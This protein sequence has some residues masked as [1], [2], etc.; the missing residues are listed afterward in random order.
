MALSQSTL[1]RSQLGRLLVARK[2]L[3]E[4]Q[5]ESV[6]LIQ[7]SSGKR[8]GEVIVDQ[9]WVT[10]RQIDRALQQQSVIRWVA[11]L[12]ATILIPYQ[13][14]RAGDLAPA[15][16]DFYNPTQK[17]LINTFENQALLHG[18]ADNSELGNIA[19]IT[20]HDGEANL[21]IILQSGSDNLASID[22]SGGLQN[23]ALV[24]QDGNN[25]IAAIIQS[26]GSRNVALVAQR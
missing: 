23:S 16:S 5:L 26:G 21:A 15:S 9:G 14:A 8:L 17:S 10:Q 24:R 12:A 20:Q 1:K 13:M 22:Q 11:V 3:T 18:N 7:Q 2:L 4:D 25:Q 6:V 19:N